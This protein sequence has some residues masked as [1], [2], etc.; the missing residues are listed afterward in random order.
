MRERVAESV[1]PVIVAIVAG[2]IPSSAQSVNEIRCAS[3]S[4]SSAW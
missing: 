1:A 4:D 3:E 2:S